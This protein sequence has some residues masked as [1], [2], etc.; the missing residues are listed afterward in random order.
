MFRAISL[1]LIATLCDI[2]M[3]YQSSMAV[4][5]VPSTPN[6]DDLVEDYR[7][8]KKYIPLPKH[9]VPLELLELIGSGEH[10]VTVALPTLPTLLSYR[11]NT[12]LVVDESLSQLR[13][14]QFLHKAFLETKVGDFQSKIQ[15]RF[16]DYNRENIENVNHIYE[17]FSRVY[18]PIKNINKSLIRT[19]LLET[20]L[21]KILNIKAKN[22]SI[23]FISTLLE[24]NIYALEDNLDALSNLVLEGHDIVLSLASPNRDFIESHL[25]ARFAMQIKRSINKPGVFYYKIMHRLT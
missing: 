18:T 21:G 8:A 9:E 5:L 19:E 24:D 16:I 12:I 25:S 10:V 6:L 2:S 7:L 14:T 20:K 17:H 1:C 11:F 13:F 3:A 23:F 22:E 4:V 15:E